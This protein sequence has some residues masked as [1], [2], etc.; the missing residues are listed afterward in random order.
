MHRA[1]R[2]TPSS[3]DA[4]IFKNN[5]ELKTISLLGLTDPD[6]L[7]QMLVDQVRQYNEMLKQGK[8]S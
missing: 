1:S 7:Y 3:L 2:K 5:K 6:P 4:L 8:K